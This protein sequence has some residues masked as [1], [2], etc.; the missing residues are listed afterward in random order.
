V[1]TFLFSDLVGYTALA[2]ERGDDAAAEVC[3]GFR[4]RVSDLL[5]AHDAE[6]V[7]FLGDGVMVRAADP[8]R[9]V[10]LGLKIVQASDVPVRVGVHTGPAAH[11]DGDW[12]GTTVN[13]A[14][15]LCSSAGD[16]QVLVSEETLRAAGD[17]DGVHVGERRLHWLRNLREPVAAHLTF[18]APQPSLRDRVIRFLRDA[19][20]R[21]DRR[22]A[23]LCPHRRSARGVVA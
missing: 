11:R 16:G 18:P 8:G 13:V 2:A 15:R 23:A 9:A 17:L 21:L 6:E 22:H 19:L 7:K 14:S 1:E 5:P 20:K 10:S 3:V 12:F 4:S